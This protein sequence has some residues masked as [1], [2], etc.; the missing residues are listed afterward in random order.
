MKASTY[1]V[2]TGQWELNDAKSIKDES[3]GIIDPS[4]A[5]TLGES[6]NVNSTLAANTYYVVY[7]WV[8][9]HGETYFSPEANFTTS[10]GYQ[11]D[12]TLPT[13]PSN[14]ASANVYI[15][16]VSGEETKQGNTTTTAYAQTSDLV[17]GTALPIENTSD[18]TITPNQ[19]GVLSQLQTT[20]KSNL[21]NSIN[22]GM[23]KVFYQ[24]SALPS[25]PSNGWIRQLTAD[26]TTPGGQSFKAGDIVVYIDSVGEWRFLVD[27]LNELQ[28]VTIPHGLSIIETDQ[29]TPLD[30]AMDGRTLVNHMGWQGDFRSQ[31][32]RWDTKT[33][34]DTA[35]Y[36]F[37]TSSGKVDNS[38]GTAGKYSYN[39]QKMHLNGK[40]VMI[41]AW[42]KSVSGTPTAYFSLK[43]KDSAGATTTTK[44]ASFVIDSTW[45]FYYIKADLTANTD[46]HWLMMTQ[47]NT[48]GTANDVVNF[49]G[50]ITYELTQAQYNEIDILTSD[51]VAEK[52]GYVDSVKH[53]Q[54]PVFVSYG[55]NLLPPFTEWNLHANATVIE[56]YKLELNAT[57]LNQFTDIELPITS[58]QAYTITSTH[59]ANM[60]VYLLDKD[61]GF[62]SESKT[63]S[64]S[65]SFTTT[66]NTKFIKVRFGNNSTSSG[67]FTFTDP[68]L[69]LG[70]TATTFE[71]Q[72]KTY[73]YGK[74]VHLG[75]LG[76]KQDILYPDGTVH[77]WIEKDVVLDGINWTW[78]YSADFAG[79]KRI[80]I[81]GL[82]PD[83]YAIESETAQKLVKYDGK[84]IP[85]KSVVDIADRFALD[86][87]T[88]DFYMTV[89]DADS[90]WLDSWTGTTL[91]S[92]WV[93]S[94]ANG[95]KY[96]GDGTTHTWA[97]VY[98]GANSPTQTLAYVS[99]NR[100][101]GMT[102]DNAHQLSYQLADA[103][104][105][106]VTMEGALNLINGLN[107]ISFE[108][109][110]VVREPVT[111]EL[112]SGLYHLNRNDRPD[113]Q[114]LD[115][116]ADIILEIYKGLDK[117][118][119]KWN[120]ISD[121]LA[122]GNQRANISEADLDE[123][124]QYYASYLVL[125]KHLFTANAI[126]AEGTY[127]TNLKT[128][129]DKHTDQIADLNTKQSQQ[130]IWNDNVAVKGEGEKVQKGSDTVSVV[131]AGF[132]TKTIT[133]DRAFSEPPI[134]MINAVNT[135]TYY[136]NPASITTTSFTA[137]AV[138]RDGT[139]ATTD[140]EINYTAIGK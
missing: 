56:P 17:V 88:G 108:E 114:K 110:I 71:A 76:D 4:T 72:N 61:K 11:L 44:G 99:S 5:P 78:T 93:S 31:F 45:K 53:I 129:V 112:I 116:R 28:T 34:I 85:Y 74:D 102:D 68:Q 3:T 30:I 90:G 115:N 10:A 113:S 69:E 23:A 26:H 94:Y 55:K 87:A 40:Y 65:M 63:T 19:I 111:P 130:D 6:A 137:R 139:V 42:M 136:A 84:I 121:S 103:V 95:W 118:T 43:G 7:A 97:S 48:Y 82:T 36:K 89:P 52:Y 22:E 18:H 101:S 133:F 39:N 83:N 12:V 38:T 67:T 124:K 24:T 132:G 92:D 59:N 1:N 77:K 51:E 119:T 122:Y 35:T 134:V 70:S 37:G 27:V 75:E 54:N 25:T 120:F 126:E 33:I 106:P 64:T 66:T 81:V 91:T 131:S 32:N 125:D 138:E 50:M 96:T 98:D 135:S 80:A 128:V 8:N 105:E 29:K 60:I 109:G 47:V 100:A 21:V 16:T 15:S 2:E 14:A 20:D 49:D 46:N 123:T 58:N 73:L 9:Q 107:Q 41:G 13:L 86:D 104:V 140:V 79:Y 117:D 127:N 57:S 62:I